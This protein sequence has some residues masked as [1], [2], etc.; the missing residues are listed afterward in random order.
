MQYMHT[1]RA[2]IMA[3][4]YVCMHVVIYLRKAVVDSVISV[5]GSTVRR[6]RVLN[7]FAFY[8]VD[9]IGWI[10]RGLFLT[11]HKSSSFN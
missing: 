11:K 3:Y 8:Y 6:S 10:V 2:K 7:M 9:V 4:I 1:V 5:N